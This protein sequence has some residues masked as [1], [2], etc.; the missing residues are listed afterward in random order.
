MYVIKVISSKIFHLST[1]LGRRENMSKPKIFFSHSSKDKEIL[2]RLKD[3]FVE[4]TG[5]TIE[6][7]LSSDGQSIPFGKNWVHRVQEALEQTTLMVVFLTPNSLKSNWIYFETGFV[8][9]KGVRVVP[10]GFIGTDLSLLPPPLSLLQGF[11]ISNHDG[12]DNLIA[13]VNDAFSH[14]HKSNF[15]ET[16]YRELISFGDQ[17]TLHPLGEF[18]PLI[19]EVSIIINNRNDFNYE[20]I[21]GIDRAKQVLNEESIEYRESE[22][23]LELFGVSIYTR[24][25]QSPKLINFEIDPS[26]MDKTLPI[27]K[28][29]LKKIREQGIEGVRFR[30][31]FIDG[32]SCIKGNHK[33]TARL[34][35]TGVMYGDKE[36]LIFNDL[37]FHLSNLMCFFPMEE[38][39]K[40]T[41]YLSITPNTNEI[42]IDD[43]AN[44]LDLLF[45]K[46]V[47]YLDEEWV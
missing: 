5:G 8:Y 3:L 16:E 17:T 13:L 6:V 4:K 33:I 43:I 2:S 44:L 23:R 10:V 15:T 37:S 34:Y 27:V 11:N 24:D 41:T 22:K 26:L 20:A 46:K 21:E 40:G 9:S 39:K 18:L 31:D 38:S 47:L 1:V 35:G 28:A 30:F 7:F 25:G 14:Q 32:I 36:Q 19:E 29:I 12:L 45:K 42:H